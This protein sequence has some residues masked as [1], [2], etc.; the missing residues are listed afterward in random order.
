MIEG[1]EWDARKAKDNA[2]KH[3]VTFEEAASVFFD[4]RA[5]TEHDP[6]HSNAEERFVTTGR[7]GRGRILTVVHVDRADRIRVISARPATRRE[8][9]AYH[10]A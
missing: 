5:L 4:P 1:F 3:G 8:R 6:D 2:A 9:E 10:E 7:S